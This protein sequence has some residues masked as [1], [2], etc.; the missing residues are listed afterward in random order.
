MKAFIFCTSSIEKNS[1]THDMSRYNRWIRFYEPLLERFNAE[2]L[3]LIDDSGSAY[4][5]D[6]AYPDNFLPDVHPES[7][8][9]YRFDKKL[10]RT[11]QVQFPGWWRSYLFSIEFARKYGY[12]KIIHIESDFFIFSDRLIDFIAQLDSGWTSL[13]SIFYDHP[14]TAIQVI[15][16]D[17]FSNFDDFKKQIVSEDY[18]IESF[19]ETIIPFTNIETRF[20]GD[21]FGEELVLAAWIDRYR[22]RM[23]KLDYFGQ[24]IL[25]ANLQV[26]SRS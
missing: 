20:N 16:E 4:D 21:R 1:E 2:H 8:H 18:M 19:A 13:Y 25:P 5:A 6:I 9:I 26:H 14:E 7:P 3:Q 15:C 11:S 24:I 12:Q 17:Q 10:G 23:Q 22:H